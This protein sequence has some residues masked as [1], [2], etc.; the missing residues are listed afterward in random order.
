MS[1]QAFGWRWMDVL[2]VARNIVSLSG[3]HASAILLVF[4]PADRSAVV[5]ACVIVVIVSQCTLLTFTPTVNTISFLVISWLGR[6][7]GKT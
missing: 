7:T 4:T 1:K 3:L 6:T 2:I 5:Y